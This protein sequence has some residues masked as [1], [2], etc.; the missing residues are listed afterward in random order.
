[1]K[2]KGGFLEYD[3]YVRKLVNFDPFFV[4]LTFLISE[5]SSAL[6]CDFIN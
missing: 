2:R 5:S 1:M 4:L 6:M 3:N